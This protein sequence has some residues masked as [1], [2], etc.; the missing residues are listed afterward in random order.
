MC[1]GI[2]PKTMGSVIKPIMAPQLSCCVT[3][4]KTLNLSEHISL[5]LNN[6]N[7]DDNNNCQHMSFICHMPGCSK[8]F[9]G[10]KSFNLHKNLM[11]EAL[12]LFYR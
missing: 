7:S 3:L 11:M 4:R 5:S 8:C 6:N 10:R 12:S 2:K 9:P 1:L